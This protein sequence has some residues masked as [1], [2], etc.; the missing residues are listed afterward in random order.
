MRLEKI[1]SDSGCQIIKGSGQENVIAVFDDSRKVTPGS[2]FVAVKGF[3]SD[4]HDY[5]AK[6]VEKGAV[7]IVF[8]DG[9]KTESQLSGIDH[10]GIALVKAESAR[11]ALAI[12]AANF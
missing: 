6:A 9:L 12:I 7:A 1:I 10:E 2:L 11:H 5:I 8:E 3:A 4:G